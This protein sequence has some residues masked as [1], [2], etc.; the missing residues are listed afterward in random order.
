MRIAHV[1]DLHLLTQDDVPL[2]RFLN[3]RVTGLLN[4][5]LKRNQ[6][7]RPGHLAAVL[8]RV[9]TWAPDHVVVTGDLT[10]LALESEF[11]AV[12]ELLETE[13]GMSPDQ[14]SV[15]PGNH[16][17]YTRG[18][19]RTR[20][21]TEYFADYIKTDLPGT[22]A[23]VALG[24]F[25]YVKLRGQVAIIGLSS[26]VPRL[27]LMAAGELGAPQREALI[28]ILEHPEVR[29][30][31]PI[32]LMH[33][34]PHNPTSQAKAFAEGLHDAH[35]LRGHLTPLRRAL[36]LHGH[37]HRRIQQALAPNVTSVGATSAS[38]QHEDQDR[39]AGF[40]TYEIDDLSGEIGPLGAQVFA[41]EGVT[42]DER[43]IPVGTWH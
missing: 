34:P 20:R 3:K 36:V 8:R 35:L 40:N 27:P 16:D 41:P 42:F 12:R 18:A 26:A 2:S 5:K 32:I 28:R 38:L 24:P 9:R 4:L 21:F 25:P 17:L 43:G 23:D 6:K 13:L 7:H 39:M 11:E 15:V 19:L 31:T 30:R 22:A 37:L 1:S 29:S 10:N 33:H 14:I